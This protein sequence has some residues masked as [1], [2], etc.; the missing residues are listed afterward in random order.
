MVSKSPY[1]I[2]GEKIV[3]V[4]GVAE[5]IIDSDEFVKTITIKAKSSN[6][7]NIYLGGDDVDDTVNDGIPSNEGVIIDIPYG[8]SLNKIYINADTDGEGVD[9]YGTFL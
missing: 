7:G 6:S 5:P 3:A 9:F 1:T 8:F 4:A 2:T